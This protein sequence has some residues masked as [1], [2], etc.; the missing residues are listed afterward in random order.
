MDIITIRYYFVN[1]KHVMSNV[2]T[3]WT[4]LSFIVTKWVSNPLKSGKCKFMVSI[5]TVSK[6]WLL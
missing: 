4:I 6:F 3:I 5:V 2:I 1:R